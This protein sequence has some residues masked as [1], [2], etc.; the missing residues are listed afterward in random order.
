MFFVSF[1][2]ITHLNLSSIFPAFIALS[3][4]LPPPHHPSDYHHRHSQVIISLVLF[5]AGG[6]A[7][8]GGEGYYMNGHIQRPY[9]A[10][11]T[12]RP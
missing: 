11:P 6:S 10:H 3:Y 5:A 9:P 7:G 2:Y 1:F 4:F 12:W 8:C